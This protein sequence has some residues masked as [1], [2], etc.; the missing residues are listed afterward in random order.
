[1]NNIRIKAYTLLED[2]AKYKDLHYSEKTQFD[3]AINIEIKKDAVAQL[4]GY[5]QQSLMDDN[6]PQHEIDYR[7]HALE[8]HLR[9]FKDQVTFEL[10]RNGNQR[11][12]TL[13][14]TLDL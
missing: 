1:M 9:I 4:A 7:S 12:Q 6:C 5:L 11:R 13:T 2:W 10:L 3:K 8:S 14:S